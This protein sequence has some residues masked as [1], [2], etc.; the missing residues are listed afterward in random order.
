MDRR[1]QRD[2]DPCD[3]FG[4]T[5]SLGSGP[6]RNFAWDHS[7]A[8]GHEWHW[9]MDYN[10]KG[11]YRFN[12]NLKVPVSD[13]TIFNAM[14]DFVLRYTNVAMAGPNYFISRAEK[15]RRLRSF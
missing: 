7:L 8:N 13:G 6:A 14:E 3:D 12:K 15:R 4:E 1:Y 9:V 10:I 11:F 2:Y 5:K